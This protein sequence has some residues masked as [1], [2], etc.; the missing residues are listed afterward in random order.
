MKCSNCSC[1]NCKTEYVCDKCKPGK[2]YIVSFG[3][4]KED[5]IVTTCVYH[6]NPDISEDK[7]I[8]IVQYTW[9]QRGKLEGSTETRNRMCEDLNNTYRKKSWWFS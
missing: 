8:E 1:S 4:R 9:Y 3:I 6:R 5:P 2:S 7:F